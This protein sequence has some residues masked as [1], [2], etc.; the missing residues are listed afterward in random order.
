MIQ[1]LGIWQVCC[2]ANA[3]KNQFLSH[4][5]YKEGSFD[6]QRKVVM[7]MRC[8][9]QT[10]MRFIRCRQVPTPQKFKRMKF[11]K[12][13]TNSKNGSYDAFMFIRK[14]L[15]LWIFLL[16]TFQSLWPMPLAEKFKQTGYLEICDKEHGR[17]TFDSLYAYF[18][19]LI[20]FLQTNSV[21]AQKLYGA[22]ERF[23]RSTDRNS[24]STD[25]FGFY[26]ES[27]REGR[28][29]ISFYYSTYFHEFICSHYQEFNQVPEIIHFFEACYEIQK[30]FGNL[31]N[32]AAAELGLNTIFSSKYGHLP[33]LFKVIKYLPSYTAT[34]PHYDG[35]AF[36]LFLD[37]TDN[38]SLLLS[39]YKPSFTV[40]DFSTPV[41][42][43]SQSCNQ[44]SILLIPG[45]LLAE[46]SIYPTPHIVAESSKVRYATI[47]FAMRPNYVPQKN[48]FSQLPSFKR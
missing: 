7:K 31:F 23:I 1:K 11:I 12:K 22:K 44:N 19:E 41:R 20:K 13:L 8:K 36:S 15:L 38:E 14:T 32:K 21:W 9:Y 24:Y 26:D 17:A 29:Q 18:D 30:Q 2:I 25:F 35:S 42:E 4:F 16:F 28:N 10:R 33:T 5:R 48:E 39:P 40:D 47:A 46:F 43:F 34:R 37:S 45:A 27:E 3:A 6:F